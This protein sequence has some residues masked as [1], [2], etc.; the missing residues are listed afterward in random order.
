MLLQK[1]MF[2]CTL[3]ISFQNK[4]QTLLRQRCFRTFILK[5]N[6]GSPNDVA[7][8]LTQASP[9]V[10]ESLMYLFCHVLDL[11]VLEMGGVA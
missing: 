8:S 7:G 9:D 5:N 11:T 10:Y 3:A 1:V 4:R 6:E 2:S